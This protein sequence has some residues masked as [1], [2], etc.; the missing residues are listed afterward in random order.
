M[1]FCINSFGNT[2]KTLLKKCIEHN[3]CSQGY[4]QYKQ[5]IKSYQKTVNETSCTKIIIDP[6][7]K[8]VAQ[9]YGYSKETLETLQ[10]IEFMEAFHKLLELKGYKRPYNLIFSESYLPYNSGV[11]GITVQNSIRYN[12]KCINVM[13]FRIP[14]HE[15]GH[16]L[17]KQL[18][19]YF[20]YILPTARDNYL[21][22]TGN[23]LKK[24]PFI[25]NYF[26]DW[27]L[28]HFNKKEQQILR[29]DIQR[30]WNEGYFK[31][32]PVGECVKIGLYPNRIVRNF[33]KNPV[34]SYIP[35]SLF[36]RF[37]FIGDYFNLAAKGFKFSPEITAKYEKY[38]G[39]EIKEIITEADLKM[40][41][42]LKKNILKKTLADYGYKIEA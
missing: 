18:N 28:C 27:Q 33:R 3:K 6:T 10:S 21:Y 12:P 31:H 34:D 17:T 22:R 37:E 16:S 2:C 35:N 29:A 20:K 13:D 4:T 19:S 11:L 8:K 32:N 24:L 42:Q 38:G 30:A 40:L 23:S 15:L 25:K 9:K 39:P 26:K 7:C 1:A 14:V 41:E 36:N 5:I